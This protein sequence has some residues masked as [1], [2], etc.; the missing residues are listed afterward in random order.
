[1][2]RGHCGSEIR[3]TAFLMLGIWALV[4]VTSYLVKSNMFST[5]D[6]DLSN[7]RKEIN[8]SHRNSKISLGKDS[9]SL[10]V[11]KSNW[12]L[13]FDPVV[14]NHLVDRLSPHLTTNIEVI[15]EAQKIQ[16]NIFRQILSG[17]KYAM[18][19]GLATN[20]NKG[21][22]AITAGQFLLLQRLNITVVYTIYEL[23]WNNDLLGRAYKL[24]QKYH[25]DELII[26]CQGGGSILS[27]ALVDKMREDVLKRFI[28]FEVVVFPQSV[29]SRNGESHEKYF[30]KVYSEHPRLT[31]LYRDRNSYETGKKLFPTV[32]ALLVPDIAFQI[33]AVPRIMPPTHDILWLSR[34]DIES[35]HNKIPKAAKNY[36]ICIEDWYDW[37]SAVGNTEKEHAFLITVNG[38]MFLQRGRVVITDRL[39]GHILSTLQSI[40]HVV[41]DTVNH[42]ITSYMKSWTGG[43]KN[44]VLANSGEDA[45][46]K[47]L[48]LLKKTKEQD[49]LT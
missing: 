42:K 19:F 16:L 14:E 7:K 4:Y 33:G 25:K 10:L 47:A 40:P 13:D 35:T 17:Y 5:N 3:K 26:L 38:F 48:E 21:D 39:H 29:W 45:L 43:L 24:S 23:N 37:K 12:S 9:N 6:T 49:F 18:M 34:N 46:Q 2:A 36:D 22:P 1:M 20:E 30:Q 28:D 32:G 44:V 8:T 41:I 11:N 27:Y 15:H 31:F